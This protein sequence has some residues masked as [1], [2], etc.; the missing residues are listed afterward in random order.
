MVPHFGHPEN[1]LG[2]WSLWALALIFL[3]PILP[4][5]WL[6]L[7]TARRHQRVAA[8]FLERARDR[9]LSPPQG[10][11]LLRI[12]RRQG[13]RDP[14]TLLRS[15]ARF[16]RCVHG[17]GRPVD[18]QTA[19]V[20]T[21]IRAALGFDRLLPGDRLRSTRQLSRG[22]RLTLRRAADDNDTGA[23]WVVE[24]QDDGALVAT[25]L[26]ADAG[27]NG[28]QVGDRVDAEFRPG[29]EETY[30]FATDVLA[31]DPT[32]RRLL[33]RHTMRVQ[34][35]QL[36]SFF[37]LHAQFPLV[38]LVGEGTAPVHLEE[39]TQLAGTAVD[40]SGGGLCL[41]SPVAVAVNS[42]LIIDPAF[43]GP[44][45]LAGARC[46][47]VA[48]AEREGGVLLRLRFVDLSG[49]VEAAIVRA[50]YRRQLGVR[51]TESGREDGPPSRRLHRAPAGAEDRA[52]GSRR[53]RP[54]GVAT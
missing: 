3:A 30:A 27:G 39:A 19:P 11:L 12:A 45:P 50:I 42:Q 54:S 13:I 31:V 33:L 34:R 37:R 40:I 49:E 4:L 17:N 32:A 48:A 52:R 20:V 51:E 10:Q 44:F 41:R 5:G 7:R 46:E 35:S 25:P 36:R 47:A 8:R 26:I 1:G 22:L 9:G 18:R 38:L 6:L 15:A 21:R 29:R 28:W 53:I 43:V 16:D 24:S 23:P 2:A 14:L